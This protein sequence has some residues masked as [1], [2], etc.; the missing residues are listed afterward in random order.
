M[1]TWVNVELTRE[2][3]QKFRQWC[4]EEK[5]KGNGFRFETSGAFNLV[6]FEC[7]VNE[8]ERRRADAFLATL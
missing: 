8:D 7:L 2:N 1:R 4:L 5:D 3:A 6:H